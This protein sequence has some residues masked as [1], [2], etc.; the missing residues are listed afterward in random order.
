[1]SCA[2]WLM[3]SASNTTSCR[4]LA[5]SKILS[6]SL[7]TSAT[8]RQQHTAQRLR[9][10]M[11]MKVTTNHS[12]SQHLQ[13]VHIIERT[14][15]V[16]L[17][18]LERVLDLSMMALLLGLFSTDLLANDMSAVTLVMDILEKKKKKR[19]IHTRHPEQTVSRMMHCTTDAASL[20][21]AHL[22]SNLCFRKSNSAFCIISVTCADESGRRRGGGHKIKREEEEEYQV[23]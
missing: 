7:W 23:I 5:S 15:P 21:T 10:R 8:R 19:R 13:D 6:I 9:T 1:M 22:P 11:N 14:V 3:V 12:Q 2:G 4:D 18:R 17:P 16:A 20:L